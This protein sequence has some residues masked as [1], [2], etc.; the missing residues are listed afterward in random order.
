MTDKKYT[1]SVVVGGVRM[2]GGAPVSVQSMTTLPPSDVDGTVA[3]ILALER[4]GCDVVR[5]AVPA[6]RDADAIA[7]VRQAVHIP[8][9][10]E[11]HFDAR[12]AVRVAEHG[13]DKI[14]VNPGNLG[15][16]NKVKLVAD[17]VRAHHIPVRVGANTGSIARAFYERY[18]GRTAEALAE[19]ALAEARAFEKCGVSD[20]VL[21]VKASD[22]PLTVAAYRYLSARCDYPL[23]LG[24]TEAGRR[25][26]GIVKSAA[27]IGALLLDGIGDTL[28]VSLSGETTEEVAAGREILRAVGLERDYV[29]VVACPTCGRCRWNAAAFAEKVEARVKGIRKRLKIAVMGCA[30]NGVGEGKDADL[31]VAGSGED[32]VLFRKGEVIWKGPPEELEERFTEELMSCLR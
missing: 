17:A 9:V 11:I 7:A 1:R 31:G 32:C 10:A 8:V 27:A 6:E 24:V 19:S 26:G 13:A 22:V 29:E 15:G 23:H 3:E 20:I 14:R 21:S 25:F 4:A 2:G 12:L 28:R 18:G 30:V 5:V 16:E